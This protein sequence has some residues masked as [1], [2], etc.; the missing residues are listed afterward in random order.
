[1]N[2]NRF[3]SSSS[4]ENWKIQNLNYSWYWVLAVF[5]GWCALDQLYVGS[6]KTFLIKNIFNVIAFG[7]P[8]FYE[9]MMATSAQEQIKLFGTP[10]PVFGGS[11]SV[12]ISVAAGRFA[13]EDSEQNSRSEKHSRFL[14]YGLV[15]GLLGLIGGDSFLMG[16]YLSGFTRIFC[17]ITIILAPISIFW[18]LYKLAMFFFQTERVLEQDWDFFGYPEPNDGVPC[19]GIL[20]QVTLWFLTTLVAVLDSIPILNKFTFIL[21]PL[22]LALQKAY[23]FAVDVFGFVIKET[24]AAVTVG[25]QI[26]SQYTQTPGDLSKPKSDITGAE[27]KIKSDSASASA[28]SSATGTSKSV[29]PVPSTASDTPEAIA[30]TGGGLLLASDMGSKALPLLLATT[31][32]FIVVSS[33]VLSWRRTYQNAKSESESQSESQ[34]Q[35]D[36]P[37]ERGSESNDVPPHPRGLGRPDEVA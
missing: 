15:L 32:G 31:V 29:A 36:D 12:P 27:Q 24:T 35:S 8:W 26:G 7:Y 34:S 5:F 20:Q 25:S 22:L 2:V 10:I 14:Q 30:M 33:I 17:L 19:P 21:K 28:P 6:P 23:G 37:N 9:A 18:W 11:S 1:M 16:N 3:F 4:L 13:T